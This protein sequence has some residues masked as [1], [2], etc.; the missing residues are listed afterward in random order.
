[1]AL[2]HLLYDILIMHFIYLAFEIELNELI[3]IIPMFNEDLSND[4]SK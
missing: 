3:N 2:F 4:S 1:M